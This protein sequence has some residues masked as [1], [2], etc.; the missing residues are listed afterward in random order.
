MQYL[1]L[2]LWLGSNEPWNKQA[3]EQAECRLPRHT[4]RPQHTEHLKKHMKKHMN[5]YEATTWGQ[6][7]ATSDSNRWRLKQT[8]GGRCP[9][10]ATTSTSTSTSTSSISMMP[11]ISIISSGYMIYP[12]EHN[13]SIR[14]AIKI[15]LYYPAAWPNPET[16]HSSEQSKSPPGN[17]LLCKYAKT[18]TTV[19][20][21][22]RQHPI[23]NSRRTQ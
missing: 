20:A 17:D 6:G 15:L 5:P 9:A 4:Q 19:S 22:S 8:R 23:H 7:Y 10:P 16:F 18:Q 2:I 1:S 12:L 21:G 13:V 3:W 11:R 14:A